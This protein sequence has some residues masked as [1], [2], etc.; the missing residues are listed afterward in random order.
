M[1]ISKQ[2]LHLNSYRMQDMKLG[3]SSLHRLNFQN[4]GMFTFFKIDP[5]TKYRVC[6]VFTRY[7]IFILFRHKLMQIPISTYCYSACCTSRKTIRNCFSIGFYFH[8]SIFIKRY[9]FFCR[10]RTNFS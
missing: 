9:C 8:V 4:R 3:V 1:L 5:L 7:W 6:D 10:M 2:T